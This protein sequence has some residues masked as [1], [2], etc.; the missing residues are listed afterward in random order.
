MQP[1][2]ILIVCGLVTPFALEF[3]TL[4]WKNDTFSPMVIFIRIRSCQRSPWKGSH[5]RGGE[6]WEMGG[7]PLQY[8]IE[9]VTSW[10]SRL[11]RAHSY[12]ME[13]QTT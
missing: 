2:G 9:M 10:L 1:S 4:L 7:V 12:Q 6:M 8:E 5:Q 11:T 13:T 3:D